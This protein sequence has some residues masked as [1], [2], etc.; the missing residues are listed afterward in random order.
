[1][2]RYQT[3]VF[4]LTEAQANLDLNNIP[5]NTILVIVSDD[6]GDKK[7]LDLDLKNPTAIPQD[8][9]I[10]RNSTA[11]LCF[12]LINGKWQWVPC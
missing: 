3:R 9:I 2:A 6:T 8:Q 5:P 11:G 12:K 1:M 7:I 10:L 4:E